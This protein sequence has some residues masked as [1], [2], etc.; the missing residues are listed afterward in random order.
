MNRRQK[1]IDFQKKHARVKCDCGHFL[2][3]HFQGSG[4]CNKCGCTWYWPNHKYILRK[5]KMAE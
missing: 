3:D 5:K 1:R 2:K 4:C